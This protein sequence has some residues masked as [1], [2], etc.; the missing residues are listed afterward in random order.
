MTGTP[1]TKITVVYV[2]TTGHVLAGFTRADVSGPPPKLADL[3]GDNLVLQMG[4]SS[5]TA[6]PTKPVGR[7]LI[8]ATELASVDVDLPHQGAAL[9]G[10]S[11]QLSGATGS[12]VLSQP[13]SLFAPKA[14][15]TTPVANVTASQLTVSIAGSSTTLSGLPYYVMVAQPITGVAKGT[16]AVVGATTTTATAAVTISVPGSVSSTTQLV[17]VL[18]QGISPYIATLAV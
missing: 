1:S 16:L 11:M 17:L 15:T 18:V 4:P 7:F 10:Q 14:F 5:P 13:P 2:A 9:W 12:L 8:P 6:T 3:V